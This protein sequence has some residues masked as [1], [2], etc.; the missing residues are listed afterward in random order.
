MKT[1]WFIR[2][3]SGSGKSTIANLIKEMTNAPISEADDFR[4]VDGVYTYSA[5]GNYLAHKKCYEQTAN[6]LSSGFE[7]VVVSNT[8]TRSSDVTKYKKLAE[9]YGY[10]FIS[11]VVENYHETGNTHGVQEEVLVKMQSQLRNSL[12]LM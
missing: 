10:R 8:S 2:G 5:G 11:L 7:H 3:V 9:T 12:K 4:Y 6:N 1:L